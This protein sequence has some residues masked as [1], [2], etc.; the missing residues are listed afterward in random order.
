L[1]GFT[2][3]DVDGFHDWQYILRTLGLLEYDHV[4][5][6]TAHISGTFFIICALVWGGYMLIKQYRS[7]R[8]EE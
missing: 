6:I 5:A 4:L 8:A 3:R 7:V 1:G 2:G